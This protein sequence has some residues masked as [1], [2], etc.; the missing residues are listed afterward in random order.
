M[1]QRKS[2]KVVVRRRDEDYDSPF[3]DEGDYMDNVSISNFS[4][5]YMSDLDSLQK[6]QVQHEATV[7]Y[8][9]EL[10]QK[11]FLQASGS[12]DHL[13]YEPLVAE[14]NGNLPTRILK[15]AMAR[16]I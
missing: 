1:Q 7:D 4:K 14:K 8:L 10:T 16:K 3:D 12:G 15:Q 6:M 2:G 5:R 11:A 13:M 9:H